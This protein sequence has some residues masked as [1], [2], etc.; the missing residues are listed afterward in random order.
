MA[1]Q[2]K[3]YVEHDMWKTNP[4]VEE[5][6]FRVPGSNEVGNL[7]QPEQQ[8]AEKFASLKIDATKNLV[9]MAILADAV[10]EANLN[11]KKTYAETF[12]KWYEKFNMD[13]VFGS[14]S[15]FSKYADAGIVINKF[16][17]KLQDKFYQLPLKISV[18]YAIA[19]MTDEELDYAI[20]DHF[21][22]DPKD[23]KII[24]AKSKRPQPIINPNATAA[25][26][27]G[28]LKHWRNPPVPSTE[29]RRVPFLVLK[30]DGSVYDF[31]K[32]GNPVGRTS[33]DDLQRIYQKIADALKD[34]DSHILADHKFFSIK[35]GFQKRKLA[36]LDRASKKNKKTS[37]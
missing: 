8:L 17:N 3:T 1:K 31:D 33:V 18:L 22:K 21:I 19:E 16:K 23:H 14:K 10:R 25:S 32:Q 34:E 7:A 27:S 6:V 13:K 30:A 26:I 4:A 28:W 35:S 11:Q 12:H 37:K 9:Q 36:A 20:R 5:L 24:K 15:N 29:K 2:S